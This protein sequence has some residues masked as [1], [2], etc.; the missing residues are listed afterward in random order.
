MI[1]LLYGKD[2]FRAKQK[3]RELT[4]ALLA[5]KG[6]QGRF[7]FFEIDE[8]SFNKDELKQLINSHH[9]FGE[10][11]LVAL[12]NVLQNKEAKDFCAKNISAIASSENIFLFLEKDIEEN[13]FEHF[14]THSAKILEFKKQEKP[15]QKNTDIFKFTDALAQKNK[16]VAWLWLQTL[17]ARGESE[18]EIFWKIFWQLKN[19]AATKPH[20]D[21]TPEALAKILKIHPFVAKKNLAATRVFGEKE[22]SQL[23]QNLIEIYRENRFNKIELSLGIERLILQ[24]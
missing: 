2:D 20:Q 15:E 5:K 4:Q 23:T 11:N 14:K 24:F 22:I 9:L 17:L 13:I 18:E 12:K 7:S 3:L 21:K 16:R 10:K 6:E 19:I 8:D 1:Y